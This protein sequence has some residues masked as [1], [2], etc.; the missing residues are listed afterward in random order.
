MARAGVL[1]LVRLPSPDWS[2]AMQSV[3]KR[4]GYGWVTLAFFLLSLAGHWLFG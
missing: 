2:D 4:Y 3:W 1:P